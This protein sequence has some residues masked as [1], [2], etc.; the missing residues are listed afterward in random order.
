MYLLKKVVFECRIVKLIEKQ[1]VELKKIYEIIIAKK[2]GLES[3][4]YRVILY[5]RQNAVGLRLI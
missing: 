5:A 4:V 3:N 2:M 1:T